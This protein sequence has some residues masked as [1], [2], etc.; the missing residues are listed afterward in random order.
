MITK[1]KSLWT[2]SGFLGAVGLFYLIY[3]LFVV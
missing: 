2:A 3:G 1:R